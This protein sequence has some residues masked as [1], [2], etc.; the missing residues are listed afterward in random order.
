MWYNHISLKEGYEMTR[1]I[2]IISQMW[3]ELLFTKFIMRC[4]VVILSPPFFL[5]RETA[6]ALACQWVRS[7]KG[8][9]FLIGVIV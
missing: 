6:L 8:V 7:G 9:L 1:I 4:N 5:F 2:A 3:R